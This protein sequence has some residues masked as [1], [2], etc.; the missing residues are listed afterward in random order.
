MKK[1]LALKIIFA[2]LAV[3]L[4]GC[5]ASELPQDD[6]ELNNIYYPGISRTTLKHVYN[7]MASYAYNLLYYDGSVYTSFY[8]N[9]VQDRSEIPMEN[10]AGRELAKVYGNH[11]IYWSVDENDLANSTLIGTIYSV[12][13]YDEDFR[14]CIYYEKTW[15]Q[16]VY[17][18]QIFEKLNDITLCKGSELYQD[19]LHL[20]QAVAV[21]DADNHNFSLTE[22]PLVEFMEALFDGPFM[23]ADA[24]ICSVI[25]HSEAKAL[26]F[27]DALG[28]ITQIDIYSEGY[29]VMRKHEDLFVVQIDPVISE[30]ITG[31]II[32]Q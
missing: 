26:Y 7:Y 29:V 6:K 20:D 19:R 10:V 16:T 9:S 24:D 31:G 17:G 30:K 4:T 27:E 5:A 28:L 23:E 25:D 3:T 2:L 15:P 11:E 1:L 32:N 18:L 21:Y 14:V 12:N 13:G 8:I 22:Q